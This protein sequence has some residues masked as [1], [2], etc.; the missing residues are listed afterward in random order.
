MYLNLCTKNKFEKFN[1]L[2]T[3]SLALLQKE[4]AL[5]GNSAKGLV[6]KP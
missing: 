4:K 2:A 1:A 3:N 6:L 5:S